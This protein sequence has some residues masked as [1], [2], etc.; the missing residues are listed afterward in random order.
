M[1]NTETGKYTRR[2]KQVCKHVERGNL[3]RKSQVSHL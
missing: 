1:E 2:V 3:A